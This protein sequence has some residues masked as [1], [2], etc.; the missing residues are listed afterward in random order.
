[1]SSKAPEYTIGEIGKLRV[2]EDFLPAPADLVPREEN[3]KITPRRLK[4]DRS[5]SP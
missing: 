3:A 5:E 2:I 1:M 4:K